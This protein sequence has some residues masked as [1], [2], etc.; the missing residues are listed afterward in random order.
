MTYLILP[1]NFSS[2][3]HIS[4]IKYFFIVNQ[5]FDLIIT[6]CNFFGRKRYKDQLYICIIM[7]S[8]VKVQLFN[9]EIISSSVLL[10]PKKK[11]EFHWH[12]RTL[13]SFWKVNTPNNNYLNITYNTIK[14]IFKYDYF[15]VMVQCF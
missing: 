7:R 6:Q 8:G 15:N 12:E 5:T 14:K 3:C 10:R 4:G 2:Q 13:T 9:E 1:I 11:F